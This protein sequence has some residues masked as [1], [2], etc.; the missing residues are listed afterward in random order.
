[1]IFDRL[2]PG[3]PA[4]ITRA[5]LEN[6]AVSLSDPDAIADLFGGGAESQAGETVTAAKSVSLSAIWAAVKMISGD[7]SRL[8]L[9]TMKRQA[10]GSKPRIDLTHPLNRFIGPQGK[11]NED[12]TSLKLWRR[13]Y[14][15][16]LLYENAFIWLDWSN[17]GQL[18]GMY[19]LLPDRTEVVRFRGRLW[20]LTE[21]SSD[22]DTTTNSQPKVRPYEDVLHL[23]GLNLN[24]L[25]GHSMLDAARDDI[26]VAL[27][28]RNFKSRFFKNGTHLGGILQVTPGSDPEKVRK[29]EKAIEEH[30]GG[31]DRSF[32]TLVLS[33]NY[34]W[35]QT[36]ASAQESELTHIDETETRN[37]ARRFMLAPSRLGVR[38]AVSYNSL[39]Q[40]R[41]D[42]HDH[43]L[44][45]H[46]S[47]V[48]SEL[49]CK[50]LTDDDRTE[51]IVDHQ[52]NL[53]LLWADAQ[54]LASIGTQGVNAA[55][56]IFLRNEVREWFKLPPIDADDLPPPPAAP[57]AADPDP[58]AARQALRPILIEQLGRLTRR[59]DQHAQRART[60]TEKTGQADHWEQFKTSLADEYTDLA[61][62]DLAATLAS[63][64]QLGATEA[65]LVPSVQL[66]LSEYLNST[67]EQQ[68][69]PDTLPELVAD[70][71]L[72]VSA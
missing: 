40:E 37:I 69:A 67:P 60:K 65:E 72:G 55:T 19:N 25:Q 21:V 51:W 58:T 22:G 43:T 4:P 61:E 49:N 15:H 9:A 18:L 30:H 64:R 53:A 2:F 29:M 68:P 44:A 11:A 35:H 52:A 45:Y 48:L 10:D 26:G 16:V 41:R 23:E 71:I 38:D 59:I 47:G 1:M 66:F 56:P 42:Y 57:P 6:P 63:C 7:C 33:D 34:K 50:A 14:E 20:V 28:A 62:R 54:T 12:I 8:P 13:A 31:A 32:K 46:L 24:G 17:G 70:H 3:R 27:A 36:Q 5:S 39:E